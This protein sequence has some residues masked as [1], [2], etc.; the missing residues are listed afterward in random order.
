MRARII[1]FGRFTALSPMPASTS[2]PE[3]GAPAAVPSSPPVGPNGIDGL[4]PGRSRKARTRSS[5]S[6]D[7]LDTWLLEMPLMP[8]P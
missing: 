3:N 7:N 8:W 6:A 2:Q 4:L 1:E 5:V